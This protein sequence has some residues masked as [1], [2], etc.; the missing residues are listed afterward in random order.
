MPN[1]NC[2][3]LNGDSRDQLKGYCDKI[4]LIVTSPP[5]AD[6]RKKHYDSIHPDKFSDWFLTFHEPFWQV[7]KDSGSLVI[8]IKDKVINGKR[9]HFVWE[10]ILMLEKKGWLCVDD[11]IWHKTN[12]MPGFWPTRL[13]DGWEYCFHL[14]KQKKPFI[15]QEAVKLPIG[16]W[17]KVRLKNPSVKDLKR[18][19]SSNES[20]L[21]RDLSKWIGKK[22][23][24]PSNVLSFALVGKNKNHPA[25]FPIQLPEFFIKL[26]CPENGIV[27]DPFAGSG[28]TGVAAINQ[29][30][31]SILIDKNI[32][33]SLLS[34]ERL[35]KE[36]AKKKFTL[37][38]NF[39]T[40]TSAATSMTNNVRFHNNLGI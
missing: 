4:D 13:R 5:Y 40:T 16:D 6:S 23:V 3:I 37:Q 20:G 35:L 17:N 11:Y 30:R 19:N 10:M 7:L 24:L 1:L 9:N 36:C 22:S 18:N 31:N 14:A 38:T 2:I 12:P 25:V 34:K 21:G 26:L 27:L 33:Y 28:T 29:G 15:N 8:N 32:E 39:N